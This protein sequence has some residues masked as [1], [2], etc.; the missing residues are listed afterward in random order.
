MIKYLPIRYKFLLMA[1][2]GICAIVILSFLAF[3]I[4]NKGV[5]N[6]NNV[7]EGSKRAQTIQQTYILPLFKLREQSLSLIMAPNEDLRK[8]I[9]TKINEMLIPMQESF[10]LLPP[11]IY[12]Q[13]QNYTKLI[14]ANQAYLKDDFEEGAFINANTS[15]RDEFYML[16]ESLEVLQQ[17][18]LTHSFQTYNKANKEA[19]NSRYF[20]AGWLMIVV[21][22]TFIFGF[23]IAKNIMDS[24]LQLRHGLREFF[25]YLKPPSIE[26]AKRIHIPLNNKDELGEMA[27]QI[28]HN[29]EIIQAN[30]EQDSK[31]IEDATHVV[32]E[33]KLDNLDRRL[34]A[35]GNSDQLN[36]L[37]AVM[38]EM[39]D[40]LE[41][42][43]Q[44][45]INERTRQERL[46][47]QQSKLAAMGNMIGN[48]AHQW[49]QPLGEINAI[50]MII[51]VRQHFKD[52]DEAFLAQKIEE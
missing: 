8:D 35:S 4:T 24:I 46:L 12:Q 2:L 43:I 36:L 38:N 20:I 47:I 45:E 3:D 40:N 30:L 51:Q 10:S 34:V 16:M 32:E 26:E 27:R 6:V 39:L 7:F 42:R 28:N 21:L 52:F 31:L 33:L 41:F 25:D 23:G 22:L 14:L 17:N 1:S 49:R 13:W 11:T 29:I 37:K 5:L 48:I 50:L 18:E 19:I 44:Q 15:E 9:L